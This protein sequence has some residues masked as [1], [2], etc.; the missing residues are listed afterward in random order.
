MRTAFA[1][2]LVAATGVHA[3]DPIFEPNAKPT[4]VLKHGAGEGPA[5]HPE[6][7]LL[8]SGD[9]GIGR[10]ARD[11]K[12]SVWRAKAGTNGLT[13]DREGRL[14]ACEPVH[15]R[16][17]RTEKDGTIKVLADKYDGHRFNQPNDVCLDSKGRIYFTDPCYGDRS[18]MEMTDA[19]G[20]KVEGVYRIDLDRKV[21]RILTYGEVDR[22]NGV[23]ISADDKYL[24]VADNN[25]DKVGAARKLWRFDLKADG[26]ADVASRKLLHDWGA[27]R[28]PDG[29]KLDV[30]GRLYV[31]G[32]LN[33]ENLPFETNDHKGGVY[34]F[35][36]EGKLLTFLHI[37][38]D[39]V[40]NTAFAGDDLR[41]LYITAG[42]TLWSIRTAVPGD[43]YWP[44]ANG[45]KPAKD[46][47][48]EAKVKGLPYEA[49][50]AAV[51]QEKGD[52]ARGSQIY[53]SQ[54]CNN[55]HTV[56]PSEPSKGPY[57][58]DLGKRAKRDEILESILKP[59]EKILPGYETVALV[60]KTGQSLQGF[61]IRE[62]DD[63]LKLRDA[64]GVVLEV[65]KRDVEERNI[66][67]TSVMPAELVDN[68]SIADLASLVAYFE[69]LQTPPRKK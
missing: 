32:G 1:I 47:S 46:V 9:E 39:E 67:K 27:A 38:R 45:A 54:T 65:A 29:I 50:I 44:A 17:T 58:G 28:G 21:Q 8:F 22:P 53:L 69:S 10:L 51:A 13:F 57:L 40:T 49:V 16:V 3:Q 26:A 12:Q 11:G 15:G 55:C 5:W 62:T 20:N 25:N 35:S 56:K 19:K 59:N 14:I 41:T 52:P 37:D 63:E 48:P 18:K 31:A 61:L 33:K 42:G 23:R 66:R 2:L 7:G 24:Y 30:K 6:L 43:V 60:L 68:I 34:V 64:Q 36:P 4:L